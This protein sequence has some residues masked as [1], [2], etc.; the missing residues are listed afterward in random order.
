ML[1]TNEGVLHESV[2]IAKF[3]AHG[4]PL[5]GANDLERAQI[6]QWTNWVLE[7]SFSTDKACGAIFGSN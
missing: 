3:L 1:E 5:L 4:T 6:D 7:L 2:A